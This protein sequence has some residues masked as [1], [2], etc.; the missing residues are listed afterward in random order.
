MALWARFAAT[1]AVLTALGVGI[2]L[3]MQGR[4]PLTHQQPWLQLEEAWSHGYSALI[5]LGLGGLAVLLTRLLVPR[6]GWAQRLHNDLAPVARSMSGAGILVLAA[7]SA[8][9]EELW[10]RGLLQ[11]WIGLVPQALVFGIVH[12]VSGRSRWI[13]I[14]WAGVFGLLLGA[15]FELTGSLLGPL[16]A[17]A[18]I[19]A[20]NLHY[21]KRHTAAPA[22]RSLGGLL[23]HG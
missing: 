12:Q 8:V 6:F 18:L 1:Y 14:V 11:S 5:G 23:G 19:N 15:L 17:H 20:A 4:L 7:L 9:A 13:W 2:A 21:L 16:V 3:R 10:F 22:R